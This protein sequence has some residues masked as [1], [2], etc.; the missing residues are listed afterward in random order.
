MLDLIINDNNRISSI[1]E[2][3]AIENKIRKLPQIE[4]ETRHYFSY[5]IYGRE[6]LIPKGVILTGKIHKYPQLN[7]ISA[8][9]ISV[10]VDGEIKRI[11]AP[12]TICS[13][14]GTKRIAYTHE[15]TVWLTIH[16]T[17]ETN[18]D[19]IEKYFIAENEQEYL[20]FCGQLT[21]AG[22]KENVG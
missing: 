15:D 7:V 22:I 18:V 5:G 1:E 21:L 9:D 13:P 2:V 14:A 16:A 11:K 19:K 12:Y 8:G 17:T 6:I 10:F 20:E 3:I 4:I